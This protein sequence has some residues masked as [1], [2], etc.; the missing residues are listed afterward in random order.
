MESAT[1]P[2]SPKS[3]PKEKPKGNGKAPEGAT[4]SQTGDRIVVNR[5]GHSISRSAEGVRNPQRY[6]DKIDGEMA[7]RETAIGKAKSETTSKSALKALT[8]LHHKLNQ[9]A[10][11]WEQAYGHIEDT[12]NSDA[13]PEAKRAVIFDHLTSPRIRAAWD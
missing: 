8:E 7:A 3:H 11:T 9:R 4:F 13:I 6:A 12:V 1:S 10:S 2:E 5:N